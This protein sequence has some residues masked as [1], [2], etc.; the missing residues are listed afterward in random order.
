M[1]EKH[2]FLLKTV[3]LLAVG[4]ILF[5]IYLLVLV[6]IPEMIHVISRVNIAIYILAAAALLI[7]TT[8][9]ASAWQYLLIPL[10]VKISMKKTFLF[11]WV[12][13]FV[14]LL[15][16]AESVSGDIAKVYLM[17]KEPDVNAGKV[18]AS[19]ISMRILSGITSTAT[20]SISFL[21]MLMLD[22]TINNT[23]IQILVIVTVLSALAFLLLIVLCLKENWTERLVYASVN[24]LERLSR[25][26]LKLADIRTRIVDGLKAFFG[27][28][29]ILSSKPITLILPTVLYIFAWVFS[30]AIVFL[31]FA[32][33]GY[34]DPGGPL[35]LLLKTMIIYTLLVAIKSIPL[36]IPAEVGLPE[37]FLTSSFILFGIPIEISA[38]VT[39]LTRILT[40]WLRF[41]IGFIAVQWLGIRSLIGSGSII[42]AKN[43]I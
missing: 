17:S 39:V 28:L 11:V 8:L 34:S 4:L 15:I 20:L 22:Y 5:F 26:R 23:M 29:K 27:S 41:F 30:I 35:I 6:D 43:K 25:G 36:G 18:V 21:A 16:P 13:V 14:D 24:L 7:E 31:V 10:S 12:G 33:I 38:A 19:L 32:A 9:F 1:N 2:N 3:P 37:I 40:V 42:D